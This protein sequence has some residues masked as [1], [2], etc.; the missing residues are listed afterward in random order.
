M[1]SGSRIEV[2]ALTAA[3]VIAGAPVLAIDPLASGTVTN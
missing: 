2:V 3:F 1:I